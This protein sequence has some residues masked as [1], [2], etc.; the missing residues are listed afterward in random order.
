[1]LYKSFTYLLTYLLY[2]LL[3]HH[4]A[5]WGILSLWCVCFLV[6]LFVF[7]TVTDFSVAEKDRGMK[8]CMRVWLLSGQVFSHFGELWLAWSHGGGI[9]SRMSN[10]GTKY[11]SQRRGLLG[12]QNWGRRHFIR[13][14]GGICILQ[15]CWCT[16]FSFCLIGLLFIVTPLAL[17]SQKRSFWDNWYWMLLL[18]RNPQC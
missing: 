18:S 13:L 15:A 2:Y 17:D 3:S 16:C 8:F 14:Y 6:C 1:M 5:V 7:C 10:A 11:R 12:S 9:T 4:M